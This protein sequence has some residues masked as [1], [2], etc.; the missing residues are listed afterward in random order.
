MRP[1][2][3]PAFAAL[4]TLPLCACIENRMTVE[5]FTQVHGDGSCTR[6]IEYRL[7]R[8][9]SDQ[10]DARVAIPPDD[11]LL[12]KQHR[13][14]SGEPWQ[15]TEQAE[16]GL[17]AVT[18]EAKLA[19]PQDVDG[20]YFRA[21]GP[22]AQ[23]ARNL[24]S[25]YVDTEHG[26]YEYQEVLRDPSSP[27]AA[28][29]VLSRLALKR[30]QAFADA[31]TE[32]FTKAT[33]GKTA[34]PRAT[35][36]RR[37]FRDLLAEPYAREVAA[38]AE[39]PFYGPRESGELERINR[40]LDDRQKQLSGRISMLTSGV[41]AEDIDELTESALGTVL[42][43]LAAQLQSQG[44]PGLTES[45]I[46]VHFRATLV[47]PAPILRANTCFTGDTAVW[48]FEADDL[49]GRG[50]EMKALASLR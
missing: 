7:E 36:L 12:F 33:E 13:F 40:E 37:L 49:F 4:A 34:P 14:L 22:Q 17:H 41:P 30:D 19:S 3:F 46:T 5:L 9:D 21:R 42:E 26:H 38:L 25:A 29:R 44:L 35:D 20:D 43:G 28:A 50:F 16:L 27:L 8:T 31:F 11:D 15:K 1:L 18:L 6:R 10:G 45:D 23:P 47:M 2:P 32:A 48:E 39:R 24:V